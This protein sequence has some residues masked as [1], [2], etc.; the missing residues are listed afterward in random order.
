MS[1]SSILSKVTSRGCNRSVICTEFLI[2]IKT[3]IL[4]RIKIELQRFAVI[5]IINTKVPISFKS[6][7]KRGGSNYEKTNSHES[8]MNIL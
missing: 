6:S 3:A 4:H 8:L 5:D 2:I 1:V 7:E